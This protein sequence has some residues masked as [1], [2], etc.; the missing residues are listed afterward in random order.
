MIGVLVDLKT[1]GEL[2]LLPSSNEPC[3]PAGCTKAPLLR[4]RERKK[5][6]KKGRKEERK[7][8]RQKET[9]K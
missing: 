2:W 7:E 6:R 5:E 1:E 3:L 8:E 9:N 4:E